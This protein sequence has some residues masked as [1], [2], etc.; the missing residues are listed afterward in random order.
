MRQLTNEEIVKLKTVDKLSCAAIAAKAKLSRQRVHKILKT[1][2][3]QR[4]DIASHKI[5]PKRKIICAYSK[6]RCY[7]KW[8]KQLSLNCYLCEIYKSKLRHNGK[9]DER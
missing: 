4:K 8:H 6:K 3:G 2:E 7:I 1:F 5:K 9:G